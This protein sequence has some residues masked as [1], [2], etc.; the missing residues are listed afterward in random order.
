MNSVFIT[1]SVGPAGERERGRASNDLA[2]IF[3]HVVGASLGGALAGV[4]IFGT[5]A[6]ARRTDPTAHNLVIWAAV[7]GVGFFVISQQLRNQ[8]APLPERRRQVPQRWLRWR[9]RWATAIAYGLMLGAGAFT[10]LRHA[11]MY[12][13][14]LLLVV[15]PTSYAACLVGASYGAVRGS[16]VLV[17]WYRNADNPE[18]D[19]GLAR[20]AQQIIAAATFAL[21]LWIAVQ[22]T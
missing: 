9:H 18:L 17:S 13:L 20:Y 6:A 7:I 12:A 4:A 10:H 16:T 2:N 22:L 14:A 3:P 21:P 1:G 19:V 8:V 5:G 15:A 11:A